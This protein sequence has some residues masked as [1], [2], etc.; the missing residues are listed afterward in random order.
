MAALTDAQAEAICSLPKEETNAYFV[1]Q[2]SFRIKDPR[3]SLDFYSR[4]LGMT[5]LMKYDNPEMKF[6]LYFMG[7]ENPDEVPKDPTEREHWTDSRRATLEMTHNWGTESDPDFPGYHNGNTEPRG[8]GHIGIQVPDKEEACE[9]FEKLGVKFAKRLT[10]GKM[11]CLAYIQDP[12]GYWI[13]I[14]DNKGSC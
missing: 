5:L 7:Y 2:T 9:R 8:Y 14:A 13:E 10:E 12:D 6:S 1:Q 4:V 3:K 11:H